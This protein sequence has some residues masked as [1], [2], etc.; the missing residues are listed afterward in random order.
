MKHLMDV[1]FEFEI[2]APWVMRTVVKKIATDLG[3][4][5]L[6]AQVDMTVETKAKYNGEIST[7]VWPLAKGISNLR[8]IFKWFEKNGI[9]TDDTCGFHVNLSFRRAELNWM[10]D[11]DRLVL[12]FNEEK[13]LK[14]CKRSGNSYTSCY[15]D[16][17]ICDAGRKVFKD[18]PT[19]DAWVADRILELGEDRFYSVNIEHLEENRPYV[20]YRVLGGKGYHLRYGVMV[21]GVIDMVANMKRAL[22]DGRGTALRGLKLK[23]CFKV[24]GINDKRAMVPH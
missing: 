18:E 4:R 14:L 12:S 16:N 24:K 9:V 7:P 8:R 5:G 1:G 22:P 13:W 3:I 6:V 10:L 21:K 2:G 23:E 11:V 20:E 19:R 15:I 17:L